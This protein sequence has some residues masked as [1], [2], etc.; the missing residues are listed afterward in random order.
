MNWRYGSSGH[1][2]EG[3]FFSA[4]LDESRLWTAV[5]YVELNPV[6]AGL[7]ENA[8]DY[9]W[10]SAKAHSNGVYDPLL[11]PSSPFPGS[12][13]DWSSWLRQG[14]SDQDAMELRRSLAG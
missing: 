14:I 5:R 10:S 6:R 4:P 13:E 1:L 2:W 11:S 8:E 7:V 9:P 3:R 12:I